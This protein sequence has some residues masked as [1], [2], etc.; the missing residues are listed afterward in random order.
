MIYWHIAQR[1]LGIR[2]NTLH[3]FSPSPCHFRNQIVNKQ[4]KVRATKMT[5]PE[6]GCLFQSSF[7]IAYIWYQ[8]EPSTH[9]I[10][11]SKVLSNLLRKRNDLNAPSKE[12]SS[13]PSLAAQLQ[14]FFANSPEER[15]SAF[16]SSEATAIEQNF[17][18]MIKYP[19]HSP[20]QSE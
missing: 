18:R 3:I 16:S 20:R 4:R 12:Q 8:F 17:S 6:S 5:P 14:G 15:S 7:F 19:S 9:P 11:L 2:L 13:S 1:N 10:S